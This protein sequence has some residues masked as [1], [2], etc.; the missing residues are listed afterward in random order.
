MTTAIEYP[1]VPSGEYVESQKMT[2]SSLPREQLSLYTTRPIGI[3]IRYDG[4]PVDPYD[5]NLTLE[6]N[7]NITGGE[8]NIERVSI[9]L[10]SGLTREGPG[11]Y[12]YIPPSNFTN[13]RAHLNATWDYELH[14]NE[15]SYLNHYVV[16]GPMP[17]YDLL[18]E[19]Q[20]ECVRQVMMMFADMFDNTTGGVPSFFE[21]FQTHFTYERVA[22]LMGLALD[23]INLS[24][25]PTTNFNLGMQGKRFPLKWNGLLTMATYLECLRHFI[26]TY[27]EQPTIQGG[28]GVAFADRRDYMNRWRAILD[29]EKKT[30]EDMTRQFKRDQLNLGKGAFLVSGGMF[31]RAAFSTMYGAQARASRFY[32]VV[33]SVIRVG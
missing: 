17:T 7:L 1:F 23:K 5:I 14:D 19:E 9:T 22:Q 4:L 30:I 32:P 27:V 8:E 21:Q 6:K 26:R 15:F 25:H 16:Y 29:E 13:T 33:N 10:E 31:G 18:S 20:R 11:V 24:K 3:E 28:T 12:S 2:L